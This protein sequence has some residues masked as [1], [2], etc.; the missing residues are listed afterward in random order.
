MELLSDAH[1]IKT[2]IGIDTYYPMF[3]KE[4]VVNLPIGFS[5]PESID[6]KKVHVKDMYT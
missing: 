6:F 3:V 1:L 2:V 4:F 5:I